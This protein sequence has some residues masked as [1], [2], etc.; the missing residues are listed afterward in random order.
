[1]AAVSFGTNSTGIAISGLAGVAAINA[2]LALIGGG[3]LAAGGAGVA[4]GTLLL[5]GV[6]AAP[7]VLFTIIGLVWMAKRNRKQQQEL[8]EKL[9]QAESQIAATHRGFDALVDVLARAT[10]TLNYI[11]VHAGHALARWEAELGPRPL[12]WASMEAAQ[13]ER[14]Q[15]F[16]KIAASQLSLVTI[17]VQDLMTS[18]GDETEHL[19]ELA[20]E[21][22]TQSQAV[23]ESLV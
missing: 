9:D 4:G 11:A 1:M 23:L 5:A 2:A 13:K 15:E 3:T 21:V 16:I 14:Y 8:A 18:S 19:I 12:D 22:L 6:V 20:D 10:E 17:N 7:A